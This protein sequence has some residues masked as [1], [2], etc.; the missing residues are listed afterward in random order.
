MSPRRGVL[1]R[2]FTKSTLSVH[3]LDNTNICDE[4]RLLVPADL[5]ICPD[6]FLE[7][8]R[9]RTPD[10][11]M[12][13]AYDVSVQQDAYSDVVLSM[14]ERTCSTSAHEEPTGQNFP[15]GETMDDDQSVYEW[16]AIIDPREP[17]SYAGVLRKAAIQTEKRVVQKPGMSS[18]LRAHLASQRPG[19]DIPSLEND[20][21]CADA[22]SGAQEP[23]ASIP[24]LAHAP[25]QTVRFDRTEQEHLERARRHAFNRAASRVR[26]GEHVPQGELWSAQDVIG[27]GRES[28]VLHHM[29]RDSYGLQGRK[30]A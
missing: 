8:F 28:M 15:E 10:I 5:K 9:C 4:D 1:R 3:P 17:T 2:F 7:P 11:C 23:P 20:S 19:V 21:W 13:E 22:D 18:L 24:T 26:R 12:L 14:I 29:K 27:A 6:V 16:L 30:W 25:R